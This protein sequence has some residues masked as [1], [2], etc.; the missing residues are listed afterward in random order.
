MTTAAAKNPT[1][2]PQCG[3][4]LSSVT[5][6]CVRGDYCRKATRAVVAKELKTDAD[7]VDAIAWLLGKRA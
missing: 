1:T 6:E 5:W 7:T 3:S 4:L 2:C